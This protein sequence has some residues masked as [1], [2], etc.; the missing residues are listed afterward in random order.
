MFLS[1]PPSAGCAEERGGGG[2]KDRRGFWGWVGT[3]LARS[4]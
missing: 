2:G 1:P 4:G 3:D